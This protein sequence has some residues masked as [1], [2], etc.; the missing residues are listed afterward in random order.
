MDRISRRTV[1][2]GLAATPFIAVG[3]GRVLAQDTST[4]EATPGGTPAASPGA[5]PAASPMASP[6]AAGGDAVEVT[7]VDIKFEPTSLEISA[8]TD[9]TITLTNDGMLQHDLVIEDTDFKTELLDAGSSADIVVNLP[10][11]EYVYYCSV[12]GHRQAGMEGTLKV[13]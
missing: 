13:S 9:V 1:L 8:D 11:G 6:A 5:S 10:A 12:A 4:P 2:G 7:A 3:L